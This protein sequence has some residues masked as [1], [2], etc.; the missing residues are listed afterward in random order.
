MAQVS[1]VKN[2]LNGAIYVATPELL[3][4]AHIKP[5]LPPRGIVGIDGRPARRTRMATPTPVTAPTQPATV[6]D[7]VT[8]PLGDLGT[9]DDLN[10]FENQG[11]DADGGV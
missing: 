4:M 9:G 8:A 7:N 5:C 3:R 2:E 1:Y 6:T 10:P 11:N